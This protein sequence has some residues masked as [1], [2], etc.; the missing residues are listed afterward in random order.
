MENIAVMELSQVAIVFHQI[1]STRFISFHHSNPIFRNV[2]T[3][4][5]LGLLMI[6]SYL[7]AAA[8]LQII[9]SLSLAMVDI[10]AILV[11]RSFRNHRAVSLFAAGDGVRCWMSWILILHAKSCRAYILWPFLPFPWGAQN[12]LMTSSE[13][14]NTDW[15]CW[16]PLV[17]YWTIIVSFW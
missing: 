6:F 8:G 13:F 16:L 15:Y 2:W 7:V 4:F 5:L 1:A 9:W 11:K 3:Y 14:W 10:Y 12:P 17:V